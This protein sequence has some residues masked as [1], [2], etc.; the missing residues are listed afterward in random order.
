MFWIVA[1]EEEYDHLDYTRAT[2]GS[3]PNYTHMKTIARGAT[4]GEPHQKVTNSPPIHPISLPTVGT[5]RAPPR[6]P[7]PTASDSDNNSNNSNNSEVSSKEHNH[8][9]LL[10]DQN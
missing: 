1:A 2:S 8:L 10:P 7:S 4:A 6:Q 5:A 3:N 9:A